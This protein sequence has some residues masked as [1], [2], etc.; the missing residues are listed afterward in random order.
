MCVQAHT[1]AHAIVTSDLFNAARASMSR[2]HSHSFVPQRFAA[3]QWLRRIESGIEITIQWLRLRHA[4]DEIATQDACGGS[5]GDG[6]A[7]ARGG[8]W[9]NASA[10]AAPSAPETLQRGTKLPRGTKLQTGTKQTT[11]KTTNLLQPIQQLVEAE[12]VAL[13]AETDQQ[14]QQDLV[15]KESA[16]GQDSALDG[17]DGQE[18]ASDEDDRRQ[19]G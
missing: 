9:Q 8:W 16:D 3:M 7:D 5:S 4:E 12:N 18:S 6:Y 2:S 17:D 11:K 1:F 13:I 10:S 14:Q 15:A 19:P